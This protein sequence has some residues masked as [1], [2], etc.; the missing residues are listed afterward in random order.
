M[1]SR[2][3]RHLGLQLFMP[4]LESRAL[5]GGSDGDGDGEEESDV[6][7]PLIRQGF[8]KLYHPN[9]H[10]EPDQAYH[11][12]M[13]RMANSRYPMICLAGHL[14]LKL[15]SGPLG[16]EFVVSQHQG[17]PEVGL[18]PN[19]W[20]V[21]TIVSVLRQQLMASYASNSPENIPRSQ[22]K[23]ATT[24]L[25]IAFLEEMS[26]LDVDASIHTPCSLRANAQKI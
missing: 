21:L 20:S 26:I 16:G 17:T 25:C 8:E 18:E 24:Q 15:H 3:A 2:R 14:Y 9:V 11:T 12:M 10:E 22:L 1:A 6:E 4:E 19:A 7:S 5:L 23:N 13:Q